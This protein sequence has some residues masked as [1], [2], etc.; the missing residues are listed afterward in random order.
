MNFWMLK[1]IKNWSEPKAYSIAIGLTAVVIFL[2]LV[3]L[4]SLG[5]SIIQVKNSDKF[6]HTLAYFGLTLSWLFATRKHYTLLKHKLILACV[7][8]GFGIIL[9][10]LQEVLT[11]KRTADLYDMGANALGVIAAT[12][13]FETLRSWFNSML[14]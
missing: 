14:K 5:K 13:T 7:L 12:L 10:G 8:I 4:P 9:E 3:S 2:S 6:G 11:S 1:L